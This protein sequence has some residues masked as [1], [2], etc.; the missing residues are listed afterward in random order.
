M[1]HGMYDAIY[2]MHGGRGC[3]RMSIS[4]GNIQ[5]RMNV[6]NPDTHRQ[7]VPCLKVGHRDLVMGR[8]DLLLASVVF[9]VD[10]VP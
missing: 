7:A 4:D 8:T 9:R 6:V 10:R 5:T 1:P 2:L 3:S